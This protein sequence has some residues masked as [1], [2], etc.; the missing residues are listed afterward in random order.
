MMDRAE[1]IALAADAAIKHGLPPALV[2]A[3]CLVES[4]WNPFAFNPEPRY[5]FLWD[6]KARA[7]FRGLTQNEIASNVPPAD[8]P[9]LIGDRDQ[10]WWLQRGSLGLMQV[11]G[12]V[13]R[14]EG[15]MGGYLTEL[16]VPGVALEFGCRHLAR[17]AKRFLAEHGWEGVMMAYNGGPGALKAR[18]NPEYPAKILKALGGTWPATTLGA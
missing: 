6:T 14:E 4:G 18:S 7:P 13:A 12:A 2:Q 11:M 8:F 1:L 5:R 15:F 3:L 10:E 9:C 17:F 16:T